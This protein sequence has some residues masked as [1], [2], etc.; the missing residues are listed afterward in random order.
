MYPEIRKCV[1]VLVVND[2]EPC[3]DFW[4]NRLGFQKTVEVPYEGAVGFAMLSHGPVEI[5]YQSIASAQ[6]EMPETTLSRSALYLDVDDIDATIARLEG[7]EVVMPK[8]D[9]F[10]G[11]TE[12]WVREPAGNLVGFA[13]MKNS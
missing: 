9:T 12:I 13:Q 7:V 11:A 2:V 4:V 8:R 3:V 5:M 10:Y 1:S 6:N